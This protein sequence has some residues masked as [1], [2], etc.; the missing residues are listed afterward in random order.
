[1]TR[2]R[3]LRTDRL[4]LRAWRPE[5]L[6]PFAALNADTR[7]MEHFPAALSREASDSMVAR[8]QAH[9]EEHGFGLWAF[10]IPAVAAFAGF[11]GLSIPRF[12]AHFTPC[13]EIG[14]RLAT[15]HW[16]RGYASEGARAVLHFGFTELRLDEIVSFTVPDNVRSRRVMAKVG[17]V[18]D[19]ADDFDH[20]ALP[21]GYRRHVL[22]RIAH[23]TWT[24]GSPSAASTTR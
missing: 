17:M 10:E 20:P 22:Y 19:P 13:V 12:T 1:M 11:V 5:D 16:G 9:F 18:H 21:D 15:E 8:I 7:V 14:W 3:E 23:P 4:L 24:H 6:A 2:L